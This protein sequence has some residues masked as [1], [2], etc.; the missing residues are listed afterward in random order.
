MSAQNMHY[1]VRMCV[2][3][4]TRSTYLGSFEA[5]VATEEGS[6]D[7]VS[8]ISVPAVLLAVLVRVGVLVLML[9]VCVCVC[10]CVHAR[11]R[12]CVCVRVRVHVRE[13]VCTH[14]HAY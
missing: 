3:T 2:H 11:V 8:C 13:C 9:G 7:L 10:V 14:T 12:A 5:P 6:E 1:H 4:Q